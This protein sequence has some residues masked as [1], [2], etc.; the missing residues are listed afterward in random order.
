MNEFPGLLLQNRER[1]PPL[2]AIAGPT[3]D[4]R[5]WREYQRRRQASNIFPWKAAPHVALVLL[6]LARRERN[7]QAC[8]EAL[9]AFE[10]P[11]LGRL[12]A[13]AGSMAQDLLLLLGG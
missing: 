11:L 3:K 4:T 8:P 13:E 7:A 12:G 1:Q 5:Q 6:D 10:W 2:P 9:H